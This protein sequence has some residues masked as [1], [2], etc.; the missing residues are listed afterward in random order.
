MW[1]CVPELELSVTLSNKPQRLTD[2]HTHTKH[3]H[4]SPSHLLLLSSPPSRTAVFLMGVNICRRAK[5]FFSFFGFQRQPASFP[6]LALLSHF[7]RD[8]G[9]SSVH[10]L[11]ADDVGGKKQKNKTTGGGRRQSV[12]EKKSQS[13][14][15]IFTFPSQVAQRPVLEVT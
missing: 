9:A 15:K 6:P 11:K 2:T 10:F 14:K 3:P 7:S 13:L 12:H 1:Q 5:F 4:P 8:P